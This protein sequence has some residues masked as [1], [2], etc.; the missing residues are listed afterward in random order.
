MM[1]VSFPT[2]SQIHYYPMHANAY[3]LASFTTNLMFLNAFCYQYSP[4]WMP[5]VF[6]LCQIFPYYLSSLS[7]TH[8]PQHVI[9]HMSA[10]SSQQLMHSIPALHLVSPSHSSLDMHFPS[11]T[12][13]FR[14]RRWD[15]ISLAETARR[16]PCVGA[17]FAVMFRSKFEKRRNR[18]TRILC[19]LVVVFIFCWDPLLILSFS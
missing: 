19:W 3:L 14:L 15:I 11:A 10:S 2:L 1:A 13:R 12:C 16:F 9:I 18:V 4:G 5:H 8:T 6:A 17:S 7:T